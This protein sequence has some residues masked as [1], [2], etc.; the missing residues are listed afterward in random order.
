M[1]DGGTGNDT[2]DALG[3]LQYHRREG[4][5]SVISAPV[6]ICPL[7]GG[8]DWLYAGVGDGEQFFGDAGNDVITVR[9]R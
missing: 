6:S 2:I 3:A 7:V 5:D 8:N 9:H 1:I 4:D